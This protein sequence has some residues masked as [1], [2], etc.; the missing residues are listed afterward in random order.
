MA[1]LKLANPQWTPL[2]D[3]APPWMTNGFRLFEALTGFDTYEAFP[4]AAYAQL[5]G[6][7]VPEVQLSFANFR[8]GPKDMIDAIVAAFTTREFVAGRGREVGGGDGLGTIILPRPIE[9]G[10]HPVLDWPA[11][12]SST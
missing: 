8:P 10:D 2:R 11:S 7:A 5:E 4:S 6:E 1:A 12:P 9:P 3:A